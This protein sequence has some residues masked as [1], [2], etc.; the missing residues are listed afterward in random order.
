[1]IIFLDIDGVLVHQNWPYE[2][3]KYAQ[4]EKNFDPMCVRALNYLCRELDA[5][6]VVNSAWGV[7]KS[8]MWLG[9]L[10]HRAGV[11]AKVV[12]KAVYPHLNCY[13]A[14]IKE[15]L[16]AHPTEEYISIND[17]NL[18]E[19]LPPEKCIYVEAGWDKGGL[20]QKHVNEFLRSINHKFKIV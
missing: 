10:F 6:I 8:E 4:A 17:A 3:R 11:I 14:E 20:R 5:K 1:M 7:S 19:L 9:D 13:A 15:W 16:K 18:K 2:E 12:G